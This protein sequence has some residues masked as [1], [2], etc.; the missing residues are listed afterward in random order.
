[1]ST[2]I[3][4]T[5][6]FE[7]IVFLKSLPKLKT[8]LANNPYTG[9]TLQTGERIYFTL[10]NPLPTPEKWEAT[11]QKK[12]EIDPFILVDD[13]VYLFCR[14][15][16]GKTDFSNPFFE[17]NLKVTATT[18]NLETMQRLLEMAEAI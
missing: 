6:G 14:G 9:E 2:A 3:K 5:F 16:Y 18:R 11:Q 12:N 8:I 10:L 17:K 1:M 13:V 4:E 7:V 15:G